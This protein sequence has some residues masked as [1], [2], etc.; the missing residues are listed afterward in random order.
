MKGI[1]NKM[2]HS[3]IVNDLNVEQNWLHL[4]DSKDQVTSSQFFSLL[5]PKAKRS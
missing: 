3:L 4:G 5:L 2:L 1:L